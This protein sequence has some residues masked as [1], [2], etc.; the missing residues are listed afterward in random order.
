VPGGQRLGLGHV[1]RGKAQL[2]GIERGQQG[3]LINDTPARDIDEV[4]A[5]PRPARRPA[6]T[7]WRVAGVAGTATMM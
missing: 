6:L 3:F 7:R 2:P 5:R 1:E 4:R